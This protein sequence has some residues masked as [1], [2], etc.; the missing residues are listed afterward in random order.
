MVAAVP[1]FLGFGRISNA[2]VDGIVPLDFS[3]LTV[4]LPPSHSKHKINLTGPSK[5]VV[6]PSFAVPPLP[7]PPP[8]AKNV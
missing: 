4:S 6:P 7:L 2:R 5:T 3:L 1:A 8:P